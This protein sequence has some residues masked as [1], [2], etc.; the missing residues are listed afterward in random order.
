MYKEKKESIIEK[1]SKGGDMLFCF[2]FSIIFIVSNY[3]PVY[4]YSEQLVTKTDAVVCI[5]IPKCGTNLLTKCISLF[6]R[7]YYQD[8]YSNNPKNIGPNLTRLY[9][10]V[11]TLPPPNHYKGA[12]HVPTVGP[13]PFFLI[14]AMKNHKKGLFK[15]HWPY[16]KKLE[17]FLSNHTLGNFFILR[18]PRDQIISM[19]HMV[20]KGRK[21]NQSAVISDLIFDFIDGRQKNFISWGVEINEAYPLLWELGVVGFYKLYLPWIKAHKFH[22]VKFENLIGPHGGGSH[23]AQQ[24]EIY[25]IAHH[26]GITF[27]EKNIAHIAHQLFGQSGTFRAGKIGSWK[28]SFTPEIKRAFKNTPGA[29]QLLIDLGYEKDSQW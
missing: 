13:M 27:D 8:D 21:Q 1:K 7:T 14:D 29:C 2:I 25:S 4:S 20:A 6:G 15:T 11:N 22:T 26:I 18:D 28:K 23:Q 10:K 5:S 12:L 9:K 24:A 3:S 17:D 16:T 19:A